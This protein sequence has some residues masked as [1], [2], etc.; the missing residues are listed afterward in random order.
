MSHPLRTYR[1]YCYDGAN[2]MLTSDWLKAE[3]DEDAIAEARA[4]GFGSQC[5]IWDGR[6]LVASLQ[7]EE[8]RTA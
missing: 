5:E 1:I 8:R 6:R 7:E 2:R 4:A 3:N